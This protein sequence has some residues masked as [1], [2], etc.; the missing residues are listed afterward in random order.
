[1]DSA[2]DRIFKRLNKT[3]LH[4]NLA[5][6]VVTLLQLFL[7]VLIASM[8]VVYSPDSERDQEGTVASMFFELM[9]FS[10]QLSFFERIQTLTKDV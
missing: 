6:V 7:F 4:A 8:E 1:M 3:S 5:K 10:T 2:W 9:L